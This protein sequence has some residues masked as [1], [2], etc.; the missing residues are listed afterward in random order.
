MGMYLI[1]SGCTIYVSQKS[2]NVKSTKAV[3][4]SWQLIFVRLAGNGFLLPK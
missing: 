3:G 4:I 2:D 1:E